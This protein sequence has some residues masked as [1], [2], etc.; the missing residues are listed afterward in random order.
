MPKIKVIHPEEAK[1]RLKEIYD[2]LEAKRGQ[3]AEV[4]K[5]QSLRPESIVMHIDL[6]ME[7]MYS[8]S[9]LSRAQRE[10]MAVIV[11]Q[12]NNCEY[13]ATHHSAALNAYWKIKK[14]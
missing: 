4:H 7:I 14:S 1:G 9:Q 12:E 11:S 8:K 13:C 3:L 5:I 6:Y 10:M 2:K